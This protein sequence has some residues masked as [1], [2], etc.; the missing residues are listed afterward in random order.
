MNVDPSLV[1]MILLDDITHSSLMGDNSKRKSHIT[2]INRIF[3]VSEDIH[4]YICVHTLIAGQ[5]CPQSMVN[6]TNYI[7][8][9]VYG[10]SSFR[11]QVNVCVCVLSWSL[12]LFSLPLLNLLPG[13][14]KHI[15]QHY[16]K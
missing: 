12:L 9:E 13:H 8:I 11:C 3:L 1:Q 5:N 7:A 14:R 16:N 15:K 2:K 10:M 4:F 6:M